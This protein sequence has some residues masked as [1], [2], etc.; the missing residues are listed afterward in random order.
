MW[1]PWVYLQINKR[2]QTHI[3][4]FERPNRYCQHIYSDFHKWVQETGSDQS[5]YISTGSFEH[6]YLIL[7]CLTSA[8]NRSTSIYTGALRKLVPDGLSTNQQTFLNTNFKFW[9][10]KFTNVPLLPDFWWLTVFQQINEWFQTL[11]L[12]F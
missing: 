11:I 12:F 5:I 4:D 8:V 9:P 10:I 6:T 7:V 2:F 1:L 3:F